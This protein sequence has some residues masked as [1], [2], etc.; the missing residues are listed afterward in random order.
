MNRNP[1]RKVEH[2]E[3]GYV[4]TFYGKVGSNWEQMDAFLQKLYKG[5]PCLKWVGFGEEGTADF[6]VVMTRHEAE[7][8]E[9]NSDDEDDEKPCCLC[10]DWTTSELSPHPVVEVVHDEVVCENCYDLRVCPAVE[11]KMTAAA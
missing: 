8:H 5:D 9:C 7:P 10:G 1:F 2:D 6:K 4:I 3:A 11:A